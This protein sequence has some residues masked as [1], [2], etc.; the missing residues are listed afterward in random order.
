MSINNTIP[1]FFLPLIWEEITDNTEFYGWDFLKPLIGQQVFWA[2]I[3]WANAHLELPQGYPYYL[4]KVEGPN[5]EWITRQA[6]RVAGHVFV[7]CLPHDY[8]YFDQTKN[9][10]FVP[11]VEWHYQLKNMLDLY[12]AGVNKKIDHKFSLLIH[13]QTHSKI[14]ALAAAQH[15]HK[16]QVL[17]SLYEP[18]DLKNIH[19]WQDT[20]NSTVDYYKNFYLDHCHDWYGTLDPLWPNSEELW[21]KF[22]TH[23]YKHSAYQNCAINI[24]NESWNYSSQHE[25]FLPG[26]FITEKTLKCLLGETAFLSNGQCNTYRTLEKFGFEFDYGFDLSYDQQI[27]DIDRLHGLINC[28]ALLKDHSAQD[29]F[30]STRAACQHNKELI[31]SGNFYKQAE[32]FNQRGAEQILSVMA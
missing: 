5:V 7:C 4:I 32:A 31:V 23:N 3:D 1:N 16:G 6:S 22:N 24:N 20:G 19:Y 12:G 18:V 21:R 30:D 29:I 28:I 2:S 13:R 10:T 25:Y 17:W 9:V 26:P 14:I 27:G 11:C 15:H 8:G